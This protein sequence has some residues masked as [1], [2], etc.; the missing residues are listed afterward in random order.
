S[1]LP[2]LAALPIWYHLVLGAW[3]ITPLMTLAI[4]GPAAVPVRR[5]LEGDAAARAAR[6]GTAVLVA[7]VVVLSAGFTY[8][9]TSVDVPA[10]RLSHTLGVLTRRTAAPLHRPSPPR[11]G[12]AARHLGPLRC[13][14]ATS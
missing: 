5:R 7:V 4:G 3:G 11:G 10:P 9:A 13:P 2:L 6:L 14:V 8:N 1:P 12:P